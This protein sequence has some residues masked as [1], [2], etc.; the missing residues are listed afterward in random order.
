MGP[1]SVDSAKSVPTTETSSTA[2]TTDS[3]SGSIVTSFTFTVVSSLLTV[4]ESPRCL[5]WLRTSRNFIDS[6]R[7]DLRVLGGIYVS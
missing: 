4:F 1:F 7:S 3:S 5:M 6:I 2:S